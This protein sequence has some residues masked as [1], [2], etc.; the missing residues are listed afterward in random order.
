MLRRANASTTFLT[1]VLAQLNISHINFSNSNSGQIGMNFAN[2][3]CAY[4]K[5]QFFQSMNF[6]LLPCAYSM[7]H[8]HPTTRLLLPNALVGPHFSQLWHFCVLLRMLSSFATMERGN[9]GTERPNFEID[10]KSR[11]SSCTASYQRF[12]SIGTQLE[13]RPRDVR[14]FLAKWFSMVSK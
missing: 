14:A 1:S 4:S 3:L 10:I 13:F 12:F 6:V 9:F 5:T 11:P 7:T 2:A 8:C